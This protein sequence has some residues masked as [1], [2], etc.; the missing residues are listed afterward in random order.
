[1]FSLEKTI[2]TEGSKP[3]TRYF[4]KHEL[5]KVFAQ[6]PDGKSE[7]LTRFEKE[8]IAQ[9]VDAHRHVL[10]KA[11]NSVIGIS[12]HSTIYKQKR[13]NAFSDATAPDAKRLKETDAVPT[14]QEEAFMLAPPITVNV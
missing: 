10:V 13:K 2:F 1:M 4:D 14:L 11:H 3:E 5:C 7:L 9:V 12:N 6:I 8:G